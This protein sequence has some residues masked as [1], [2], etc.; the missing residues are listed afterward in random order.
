MLE[1]RQQRNVADLHDLELHSGNI[2][3][4]LALASLSSNTGFVVDLN[5]V[6]AAVPGHE[7]SDLLGVLDQL[8]TGAF[9]DGRVGLFRFNTTTQVRGRNREKELKRH[10]QSDILSSL[11][12]TFN[13]VIQL[14]LY[15]VI[16]L[17]LAVVKKVESGCDL[18]FLKDDSLGV[19]C[20]TEGVVLEGSSEDSLS[21]LLVCP[22]AESA[23]ILELAT[24]FE[25][26]WLVLAWK[27]ERES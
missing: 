24:C 12:N 20:S 19:G 16:I 17:R 10:A 3:Y 15:G 23:V 11:P 5:K 27:R 13:K 21:L 8:D 9:T 25:T 22:A 1:Q 26:S 14:S 18:H 2:C 4:S 6:Q 7:S